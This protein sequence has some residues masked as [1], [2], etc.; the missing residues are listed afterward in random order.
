MHF[1]KRLQY[2]DPQFYLEKKQLLLFFFFCPK[3]FLERVKNIADDN[4]KVIEQFIT[5]EIPSKDRG[6]ENSLNVF[7]MR[8]LCS[9]ILAEVFELANAELVCHKCRQEED[10]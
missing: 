3:M 7:R 9:S 2:P 1:S 4:K 10:L 8:V 6:F 5:R